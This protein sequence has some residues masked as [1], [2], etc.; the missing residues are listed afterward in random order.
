MAARDRR[1]M[2]V[3]DARTSM[4]Q[5]THLI[6]QLDAMK[7]QVFTNSDYGFTWL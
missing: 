7:M 2:D 6:T 4:L 5:H 3:W 1:S